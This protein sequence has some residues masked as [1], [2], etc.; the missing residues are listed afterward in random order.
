MNRLLT[1]S[2]LLMTGMHPFATDKPIVKPADFKMLTGSPW[3]GALTYLD[4]GT[5]KKVSIEC[6]V[7]VAQSKI[8]SLAWE[9]AYTYPKEPK[10]N[11]KET[12]SMSKDGKTLDEAKVMKREILPD[13][14]VRI[15]TQKN[16]MDDDRNALERFTYL[17]GTKS[18]SI[19][20][21]VRFEGLK[22]FMERNQ[23][24]WKK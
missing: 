4:Y 9:F 13:H 19:K 10:A 21:E 11:N 22:E 8:S 7:S 14:T 6:N 12:I 24:S 20:K 3:K 2:I 5:K 23:Y 18:F 1:I 17:F 15:V 16:G